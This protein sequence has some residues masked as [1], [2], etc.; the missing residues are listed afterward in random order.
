MHVGLTSIG[1]AAGPLRHVVVKQRKW[2]T[3][4]E[5][6]ELFGMCQALPGAT[7][8]NVA[9]LFGDRVSG[10]V[11]A[12]AGVAGLCIPSL[13][14]ALLLATLATHVSASNPRFAAAEVAVTAAVAGVFISNG[15]R[16]IATLWNDKP[17]VGLA[18]R[19]GRVAVSALGI[20]LVAG[21]HLWIPFAVVILVACGLAIEWR[22]ERARARA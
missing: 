16:L 12:L 13:I 19:L 18:L 14:V 6:G 9:V 2:L 3:E 15:L 22:V 10:P 21:F 7:V 8:V 4:G 5:L 1:G 20:V 17:D 11:G